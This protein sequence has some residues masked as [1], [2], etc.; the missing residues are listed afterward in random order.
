MVCAL[1]VYP[2]ILLHRPA[3]IEWRKDVMSHHA[4]ILSNTTTYVRL[5]SCHVNARYYGTT[6]ALLLTTSTTK[7]F[8][9]K[10]TCNMILRP[11]SSFIFHFTCPYRLVVLPCIMM[12]SSFSS[13]WA[14]SHQA[15]GGLKKSRILLTGW[16]FSS[17]KS[18]K[19]LISF[20]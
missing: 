5:P 19:Q 4:L 1:C 7:N 14:W 20:F 3:P 13:S 15:S 6:T 16:F 8:V 2:L 9:N 17:L 10:K 12:P 11:L 18:K